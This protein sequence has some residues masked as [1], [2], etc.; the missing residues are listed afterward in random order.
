MDPV[1]MN[2]WAAFWFFLPSSLALAYFVFYLT[3][4]TPQDAKAVTAKGTRSFQIVPASPE[5][6][7]LSKGLPR[8]VDGITLTYLGIEADAVVIDVTILALDPDYAYRRKI[9][10]D[11]AE[12]GFQIAQQGYR[13]V[14]ARDARLTMIK[15][16]G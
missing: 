2:K 10:R 15:I 6:V 4:F 11:I 13:L 12:S 5:R 3:T 1:R 7:V 8:K 14:S 9:P 16:S